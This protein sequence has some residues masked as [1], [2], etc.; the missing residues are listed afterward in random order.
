[1]SNEVKKA[2]AKVS[3]LKKKMHAAKKRMNAAEKKG[4]E[5][6]FKRAEGHFNSWS[7]RFD[8]ATEDLKKAKEANPATMKKKVLTW[9]GLAVTVVLTGIAAAMLLGKSEGTTEEAATDTV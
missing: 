4:S 5:T 9:S 8:A 2:K 1:M 3:M 6:Q 7:E